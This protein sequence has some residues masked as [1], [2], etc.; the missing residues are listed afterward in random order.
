MLSN[1]AFNCNL[2][3]SSKKLLLKAVKQVED[4]PHV[5]AHMELGHIY[6]QQADYPQA[7][8]HYEYA[9]HH[10]SG[11][12]GHLDPKVPKFATAPGGC[13]ADDDARLRLALCYR[14]G[15]VGRGGSSEASCFIPLF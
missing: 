10:G 8:H 1:F 14:L 9:A 4:N 5:S 7:R 11:G 12:G 2:R 3:P 15:R 6:C 13:Y